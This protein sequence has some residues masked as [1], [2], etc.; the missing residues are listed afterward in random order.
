MPERAVQ[1]PHEESGRSSEESERKRLLRSS[2]Q[3]A[4]TV[5]PSIIERPSEEISER[6][7]PSQQQVT[8]WEPPSVMVEEPDRISQDIRPPVPGLYARSTSNDYTVYDSIAGGAGTPNPG[9]QGEMYGPNNALQL[10]GDDYFQ[11]PYRRAGPPSIR[12]TTETNSIRAS[13]YTPLASGHIPRK[14]VSATPAARA[15]WPDQSLEPGEEVT[16]QKPPRPPQRRGTSLYLVREGG[17]DENGSPPPGD[18]LRFPLMSWLRG[19]VR[20]RAFDR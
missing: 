12:D 9:N 14:S 17:S 13:R 5:P 7:T 11:R 6:G 18:F 3:S 15:H 19:P 16:P 20:N 1:R 10:R 4:N 2:Y 8:H